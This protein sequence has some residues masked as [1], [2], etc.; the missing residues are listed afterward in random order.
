MGAKTMKEQNN[1]LEMPE[2]NRPKTVGDPLQKNPSSKP[3]IDRCR[4]VDYNARLVRRDSKANMIPYEYV[5]V[6]ERVPYGAQ[7]QLCCGAKAA[8]YCAEC[9]MQLCDGS[10]NNCDE[11]I[12]KII[13]RRRHK[14][15]K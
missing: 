8:L 15:V 3:T 4:S 13:Q 14:R 1:P 12:H 6:Q 11:D 2:F 10:K 5:E 9:K 7:C